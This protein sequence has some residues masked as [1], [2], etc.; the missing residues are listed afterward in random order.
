M[1]DDYDTYAVL[2]EGE[3]RNVL[4]NGNGEV[5]VVLLDD[6]T[7][8]GRGEESIIAYYDKNDEGYALFG[9]L[10]TDGKVLTEKRYDTLTYMS[11]RLAVA[12][13]DKRLV[14]LNELG[15]EIAYF[16]VSLTE[17]AD[18]NL[19]AIAFEEDLIAVIGANDE[20]VLLQLICE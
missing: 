1:N 2:A 6:C 4:I 5:I 9:L 10:D 16:D 15:G 20:L 11:N 12:V 14:L 17:K 13:A 19:T 8:A 7:M 18:S 3:H